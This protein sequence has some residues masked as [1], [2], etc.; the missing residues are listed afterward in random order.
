MKGDSSNGGKVLGAALL[1][2]AVGAASVALAHKPTRKK[3][4]ETLNKAIN[5]GE[6]KIEAATK[7]VSKLK[8]D[9]REK[10]EKELKKVEEKLAGKK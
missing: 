10:A 5:Q 9:T 1:G 7:K 4:K 8:D 2:V 3:V 6:E